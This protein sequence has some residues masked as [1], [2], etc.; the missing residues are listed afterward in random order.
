MRNL[1]LLSS[2]SYLTTAASTPTEHSQPSSSSSSSPSSIVVSNDRLAVSPTSHTL[3]WA[4]SRPSTTHAGLVT[5]DV[6]QHS[7][8]TSQSQHEAVGS[9]H[10]RSICSFAAPGSPQGTAERSQ[11]LSLAYL[12]DAAQD[13]SDALIIVTSGGDIGVVALPYDGSGQGQSQSLASAPPPPPEIV[14]SVEQGILAAAWSPDEERLVLITA[15][16]E[17]DGPE[18]MLVMSRSWEVEH[19]S[20]LISPDLGKDT[21]VNLGWGSIETQFHG[22]AGKQGA[23]LA[24]QQASASG[25]SSILPDDDLLPRISWRSNSESF[26]VSC[27]SQQSFAEGQSTSSRV[28]RIYDKSGVLSTINEPIKGLSHI[29]AWKPNSL[30]IASSQRFG[31][32]LNLQPGRQ[33]RHDVVFVENNG[34]R[35]GEFSLREDSHSMPVV[36]PFGS[37][38]SSS[39]PDRSTPHSIQDL[40]WNSDG[41]LLAI[42]L[43]RMSPTA[44]NQHLLQ[45]WSPTNYCWTLRQELEVAPCEQI[46]HCTWHGEDVLSLRLLTSQRVISYTFSHV[47]ITSNEDMPHDAACAAVMDG[48]HLR[49]TPLRTR[50]V[51]PPFAAYTLSISEAETNKDFGQRSGTIRHVAWCDDSTED[52]SR[53]IL[54]LLI[55]GPMRRCVLLYACEWGN[56][57]KKAPQGGWPLHAPRLLGEVASLPFDA[58]DAAAP[59]GLSRQVAVSKLGDGDTGNLLRVAILGTDRFGTSDLLSLCDVEMD[60]TRRTATQSSMRDLGL[61]ASAP[62]VLAPRLGFG[63]TRAG[64]F[65]VHSADGSVKGFS[66]PIEGVE[67]QDADMQRL[68]EWCPS[69]M[70]RRIAHIAEDWSEQAVGTSVGITLGLS[71]SGK[72]YA[73]ER[74]IASD[75]TSF[76]LSGDTLVWS[77]SAHRLKF[78]SLSSCVELNENENEEGNSHRYGASDGDIPLSR[79]VERGSRIVTAIPSSMSIVLQMPRGNLE[80]IYPRP[81]I[82]SVVRQHLASSQYGLAF[83][84]CRTHRIDLNII[85]QHS[86]LLSD[87]E[88]FVTQLEHEDH[89]NLF[90]SALSTELLHADKLNELCEKM[91]AVLD[92]KPLGKRWTNSCLVTFVKQS[93]PNFEGALLRLR[94]IHVQDVEAADSAC[95]YLIFLADAD[96]LYRAA[97]GLYDFVLPLLVA[98]HSPRK[99]PREYLEELRSIRAIENVHYQRYEIDDRL[100]RHGKALSWIA[101]AGDEHYEAAVEYAER[102]NLEKQAIVAWAHEPRRQRAAYE[103]YGDVLVNKQKYSEAGAAFVLARQRSKAIDAYKR[104]DDW[105]NAFAIAVEPPRLPSTEIELL[106][107]M[108]TASLSD[109][110]RYEDAARVAIEYAKDVDRGIELLSTGRHFSEARRMCAHHSRMDLVETHVKPATLEAQTTM[111]DDVEAMHKQLDTTLVRMAELRRKK[112]ESPEEFYPDDGPPDPEADGRSDASTKISALSRFTRFTRFTASAAGSTSI[113]GSDMSNLTAKQR[114]K[115]E[116]KRVTGK[117]GSVYEEDYLFESLKKLLGSRLREV[118]SSTAALVPHLL[119][120]S[121]AHRSAASV[122]SASLSKFEI[123]AQSKLRDLKDAL[124]VESRA[125]EEMRLDALRTSSAQGIAFEEL[126]AAGLFQPLPRRDEVALSDVKW[127]N[128]VEEA[129]N[130]RLEIQVDV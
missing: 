46:K 8:L 27:I 9:H 105:L 67:E 120:L 18:K 41:S 122:L 14:G 65:C 123:E 76:V 26:V 126:A 83:G 66:G 119:V 72:L 95:Q 28:L 20:V 5:F 125:M 47:E 88:L 42:H 129:A 80:T 50:N 112:R 38:P 94:D 1:V 75:A 53:S 113:A 74:C 97:L 48:T 118:Q 54:A 108:L 31:E 17:E 70:H 92:R 51:P 13:G 21:F 101:R 78:L 68:T 86:A 121:G 130:A 82:L 103:R 30:L 16:S 102:H 36:G 106:A 114:K 60:E 43:V 55:C 7:H 64:D 124:L 12:S 37:L 40:T 24:S 34:L 4:T 15:A 63:A 84:I 111:L 23:A 93:P 45:I 19:E 56:L 73:N 61:G 71:T 57:A 6:Y 116:K 77:T 117:K 104:A 29:A 127:R 91:R 96:K 33:G 62:R 128:A 115:E 22:Q 87:L 59:L 110:G 39:L 11:V 58:E 100:G 35:H 107:D 109:A 98:Q 85:A 44:E 49:L 2:P 79:R 3:Y 10:A 90:L 99:D 81:L 25:R 32:S 52:A 89:L 69:I